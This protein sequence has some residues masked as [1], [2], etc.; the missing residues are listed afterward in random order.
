MT[1]KNHKT[2]TWPAIVQ[3]VTQHSQKLLANI[4]LIL[5][6]LACLASHFLLLNRILRLLVALE[7]SFLVAS[8]SIFVGK[9]NV[10]HVLPTYSN[11][12][13]MF[14]NIFQ[15]Y[16][17]GFQSLISTFFICGVPVRSGWQAS[18]ARWSSM[19]W[20]C[21]TSWVYPGQVTGDW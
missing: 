17:N 2:V 3:L 13:P 8:I 6:C 4:L 15:A 10:Y 7:A 21:V 12:I 11:H 5:A 9:V 19:T 14:T 20:R 16:S 1:K 18:E